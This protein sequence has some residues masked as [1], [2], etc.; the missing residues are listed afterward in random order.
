[1]LLKRF[2]CLLTVVALLFAA[3][4][5]ERNGQAGKEE[6]STRTGI[7]VEDVPVSYTEEQSE[8]L[9]TRLAELT[10]RL[11]HLQKGFRPDKNQTNEIKAYAK[12][13]ILPIFLKRS[14]HASEVESLCASAE[15]LCDA[16]ESDGGMNDWLS[17]VLSIHRQ[18]LTLLGSARA[19]GVLYDTVLLWLDHEIDVCTERYE[20]YGYAWYFE[21]AERYRRQRAQVTDVLGEDAFT[22]ASE[23]LFIG[24]SELRAVLDGRLTDDSNADLLNDAEL[25]VLLQKQAESFCAQPITEQQWATLCGVL[26]G[27]LLEQS[28]PPPTLTAAQNAE[29]SVWMRRENALCGIGSTIPQALSLY[30]AITNAMRAEDVAL[31]RSEDETVR[32]GTVCRLLTQCES[33]TS[34]YLEAFERQIGAN[35]ALEEDALRKSWKRQLPQSCS[36]RFVRAQRHRAKPTLRRCGSVLFVTD[37]AWLLI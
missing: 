20:K 4:S 8:A 16:A 10:V 1:M 24:L 2:C 11:L 7:V 6:D 29:W 27:W 13:E 32:V 19:G 25:V 22:S 37:T 36:R 17:T 14:V 21:D 34:L 35:A 18:S 26:Q 23:V 5:C 15:A 30:K 33:Q 28:A 3:T 31:L 9:A 12:H